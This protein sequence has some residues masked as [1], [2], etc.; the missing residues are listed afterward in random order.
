MY[1][2]RVVGRYFRKFPNGLKARKNTA[3]GEAPGNRQIP[4]IALYRSAGEKHLR[5]TTFRE[6]YIR[7]S[8]EYGI[9]YDEVCMTPALL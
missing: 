9:E 1:T 6:E 2:S 8:K 5:K 4:S 7:L 3:R